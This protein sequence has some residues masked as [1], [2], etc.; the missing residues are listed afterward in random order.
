MDVKAFDHVAIVVRSLP[1]AASLFL[2]A[3]GGE[4]MHGGDEEGRE[5]RTM[6]IRLA[7]TRVELL[8]PLTE[9]CHLHRY[10]DRFGEGFHHMTLQV[11]EIHAAVEELTAHG[12]EVVDLND[13]DAEWREVYIRP[14]SGFGTLIQLV[15]TSKDW[16]ARPGGFTA[17]HVLD[18]EVVWAGQTMVRRTPE[19]G[20]ALDRG[21]GPRSTP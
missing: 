14:S 10:L 7:G 12:Y 20:P 6:Q 15:E 9:R 3:L 1:E 2:G 8:Q 17:Q 21:P 5:M 4:F 19:M 16:N 18:G 13:E 11:P